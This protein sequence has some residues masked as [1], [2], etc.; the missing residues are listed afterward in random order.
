MEV[1]RRLLRRRPP[2]A[3]PPE[4]ACP[5]TALTGRWADVQYL[6]LVERASSFYCERCGTTFSGNEGRRLLRARWTARR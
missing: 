3:P 6:G 5:H 1:L 4:A 2:S